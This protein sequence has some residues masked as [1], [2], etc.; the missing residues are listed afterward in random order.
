M[1]IPD[2]V[3]AD[4]SSLQDLDLLRELSGLENGPICLVISARDTPQFAASLSVLS[5]RAHEAH[6]LG[7]G[8]LAAGPAQPVPSAV[9]VH[10]FVTLDTMQGTVVVVSAL[11]EAFDEYVVTLD[12]NIIA[13]LSVSLNASVSVSPGGWVEVTS[14]FS[15]T[16][17]RPGQELQLRQR[18]VSHTKESSVLLWL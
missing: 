17:A 5:D 8:V 16:L 7:Q 1:G 6:Q 3:I 12:G 9:T 11:P 4:L 2:A 10:C 14:V 18:G 13:D 15:G